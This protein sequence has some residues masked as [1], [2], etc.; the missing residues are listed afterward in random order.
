MEENLNKTLEIMQ[1]ETLM[2]GTTAKNLK[3]KTKTKAKKKTII[4]TKAKKTTLKK[5]KILQKPPRQSMQISLDDD[6]TAMSI[7]NTEIDRY[8][9]NQYTIY[10]NAIIIGHGG[11]D[12]KLYDKTLNKMT[13]LN[14]CGFRYTG[15]SNLGN[16]E[17]EIDIE[18]LFIQHPVIN[19]EFTDMLSNQY[20]KFANV[21]DQIFKTQFP[22]VSKKI[23]IGKVKEKRGIL[24][25]DSKKVFGC[26]SNYGANTYKQANKIYI[27]KQPD[28]TSRH[29]ELTVNGPLVKILKIKY[30]N[31]T[32]QNAEYE[33]LPVPIVIPTVNY[34]RL[35]D[36]VSRIEQYILKNTTREY[37]LPFKKE[38]TSFEINI[39]D[40][41]CNAECIDIDP[42]THVLPGFIEF[43][44]ANAI[45][46]K[47]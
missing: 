16:A 4:K 22:L 42:R 35:Q 36:I 45:S 47:L 6:P 2:G 34:I 46:I 30:I 10:I 33:I 23:S 44:Q 21:H 28:D 31:R 43:M 13:K 25:D 11:V 7:S 1:N 14:M 32:N 18:R 38:N 12:M 26:Q 20:H 41:T 19:K 3:S 37:E 15:Y 39:L 8:I 5:T 9:D 27:G 17:Y 24:F 40:L 29:P